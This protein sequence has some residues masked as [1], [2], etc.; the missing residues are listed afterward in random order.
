MDIR[1]DNPTQQDIWAFIRAMN[2][3]WTKGDPE[4]L[5][6]FFHPEMIAVTPVDRLRHESGAAC[7][8]G[9]S[10]FAQAV[11]ILSWQER[12]PLIRV[13]GDAAVVCYYYDTVFEMN[14]RRIESSG[15]DLFYLIRD[16]GRWL[17]VADQ[18][19]PFPG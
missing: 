3:A 14:G 2:D 16:R 18:F 7:V 15:R 9:W 4:S 11:H 5:T 19:S 8:A 6:D 10:R 17:V 12:E 1:F 13:F